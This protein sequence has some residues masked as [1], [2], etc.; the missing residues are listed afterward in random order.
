MNAKQYS[1]IL[2][3]PSHGWAKAGWLAKTYIQQ[4]CTDIGC[5]LEDLPG[6]MDDRRDGWWERVREIR[7]GSTTMMM[8]IVKFWRGESHQGAAFLLNSA[9][10]ISLLQQ[11]TK[12]ERKCILKIN[13][14]DGDN[15]LIALSMH[16]IWRQIVCN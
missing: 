1:K 12:P 16:M 15:L 11:K 5:S 14:L 13:D 9:Q 10:M 6:A 4:L 2:W 3:T 7:V 8:M